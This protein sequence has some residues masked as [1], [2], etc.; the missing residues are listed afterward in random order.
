MITLTVPVL[1]PRK[2]QSSPT[3]LPASVAVSRK[4][5]SANPAPFGHRVTPTTRRSLRKQWRNTAMAIGCSSASEAG[6]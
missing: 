5:V 1:N 3:F 6:S 4:A 2:A